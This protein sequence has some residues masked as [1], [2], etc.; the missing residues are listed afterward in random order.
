MAGEEWA[1]WIVQNALGQIVH[2]N[3]DNSMPG[4]YDLRIGSADAPDVAIECVGAVDST[5]SEKWNIGP[6]K[7]P[8]TLPVAG[9]WYVEIA[10]TARVKTVKQNLAVLLTKLE[11]RGIPNIRCDHWLQHSDSVLYDEMSILGITRVSCYQIPGTGKVYFTMPGAGGFVDHNGTKVP[12]WLADF[13]RDSRHADVL[14][15]L[16]RSGAKS[17]HAFVIASFVGVPWEV[18]SYLTGSLNKVPQAPA[19]LPKP[20]TG[21]WLVSGFGTKGLHWNGNAWR[22]VT[23]RGD[24]IDAEHII[25]TGQAWREPQLVRC[26]IPLSRLPT[27]G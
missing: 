5:Y 6:A 8:L 27:P 16:Q 14:S 10:P 4:M 18:E 13:L 24:A 25:R 2:I 3:D 21:A 9:N 19:N 15:K 20:I 22:I 17:C 11:A 1:R 26:H 23:T 7:G 12:K